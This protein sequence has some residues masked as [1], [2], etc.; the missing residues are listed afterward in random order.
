[1]I[2]PCQQYEPPYTLMSVSID[3]PDFFQEDIYLII[4]HYTGEHKGKE[5]NGTPPPRWQ[6]SAPFRAQ[7]WDIG[8][9]WCAALI[10]KIPSL[11]TVTNIRCYEIGT[12]PLHTKV[13][14]YSLNTIEEGR[15]F[16]FLDLSTERKYFFFRHLPR[17]GGVT[18]NAM[19][20]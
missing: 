14:V 9:S 2:W 4:T 19:L 13:V 17:T 16:K 20:R 5:Y 1:M 11:K 15:L 3:K 7:T 8:G 6:A 10:N 12:T 18:A